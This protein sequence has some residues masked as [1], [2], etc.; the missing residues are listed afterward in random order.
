MFKKNAGFTLVELMVTVAII[1]ILA[2]IAIPS[3]SNYVIRS[4]RSAAQQFMLAIAS[5]Q[6]QYMLDNR[7]YA[8]TTAALGL[9]TLPSEISGKY[10]F[11]I[12]F[13][14]ATPPSYLITATPVAGTGQVADGNLTLDN[15]GTKGPSGKW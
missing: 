4:N 8:S 7:S 15:L 3:Y 1:G 5:K 12:S 2:S 14:T 10:T 13:P 9:T 6:E 11:S